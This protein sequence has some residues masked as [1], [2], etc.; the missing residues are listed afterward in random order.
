MGWI[1]VINNRGLLQEHDT[2]GVD[3]KGV[4]EEGG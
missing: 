2:Q 1:L 4:L 3:S